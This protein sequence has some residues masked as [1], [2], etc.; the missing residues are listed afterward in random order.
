MTSIFL[1]CTVG[2][3][4]TNRKAY[5]LV[6]RETVGILQPAE[7]ASPFGQVRL[8]AEA[9]VDDGQPEGAAAPA[10][11]GVEAGQRRCPAQPVADRVRV[12]EQH[13]RGRLERVAL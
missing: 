5:E 10:V 7:L 1:P 12:H 9:A 6:A 11:A 13:A 2:V 8:V 4:H 3:H